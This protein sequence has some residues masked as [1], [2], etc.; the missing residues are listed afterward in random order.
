MAETKADDMWEICISPVKYYWGMNKIT[1]AAS[2]L[3][4]A[5]FLMIIGNGIYEGANYRETPK[6]ATQIEKVNSELVK[7]NLSLADLVERPE[8]L[9]RAKDLQSQKNEILRDP[10]YQNFIQ[11]DKSEKNRTTGL[12]VLYTLSV[13]VAVGGALKFYHK[14]SR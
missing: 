13:C 4:P 11:H 12:A 10:E 7:V 5:T 8:L 2:I 3:L 14:Q 9:E 6:S 1:K